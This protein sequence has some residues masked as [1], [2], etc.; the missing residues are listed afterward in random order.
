MKLNFKINNELKKRI[1]SFNLIECSLNKNFYF[2][3]T[4]LI[5]KKDYSFEVNSTQLVYENFAFISPLTR[6]FR[7]LPRSVDLPKL[8]VSS[9]LS[10]LLWKQ[11][12]KLIKKLKKKLNNLFQKII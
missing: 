11:I 7:V 2:P 6:I 5:H 3:I 4:Y 10:N 9:N 1:K 8:S 12:L